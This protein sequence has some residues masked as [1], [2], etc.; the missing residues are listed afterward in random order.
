MSVLKISIRL[1]GAMMKE[2][3]EAVKHK[4]R[5]TRL[6]G[7]CHNVTQV[8]KFY[9]VVRRTL[10]THRA[11]VAVAIWYQTDRTTCERPNS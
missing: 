11:A 6:I 9:Q 10:E 5:E 2:Q 3:V 1:N 7:N 8:T 4:H